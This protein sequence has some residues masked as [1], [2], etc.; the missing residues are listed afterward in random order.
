MLVVAP[1][2][3]AA[4]IWALT[5][6]GAAGL[7]AVPA[8]ASAANLRPATRTAAVSAV[9]QAPAVPATARFVTRPQAA[10]LPP[11]YRRACPPPARPGQMACMA[12]VPAGRAA[13]SPDAV[14]AGYDPATLQNAY[15]LTAAAAKPA[16]GETVAIVDAYDDPTAAHDVAQ[17]RLNYG[18]PPCPACLKVVN[19]YGGSSP[20]GV[21][22]AGGWELEESVD[23]EM[24]SAI[25]PNC[26]ILLVEAN[27][28]SISDLSAAER[29]ATLRAN[30]VSNSWGSGAEF[31]GENAF[32][33]DFYR[34]GVAIT[35]AAGDNGYGTQFPAVSPYVTAVGGTTLTGASPTSAGSQAAW[36]GTGSGCAS[37]EPQPSWQAGAVPSG[38]Q[39]RTDADLSADADPATG[40]AVYDTTLPFKGW[41]GSPI[42]GTSVSTPIV[43]ASYAL[44]D[45]SAGGPGDGLIPG[46]FPAAYPYQAPGDFTDVTAGSNGSCEAGRAYLCHGKAGYDGPTGLGTPDGTGGL[47]GPSGNTVSVIS[48]GTQV[49]LPGAPVSLA[50]QALLTDPAGQPDYSVT[51]P[52][53]L[54]ANSGGISGTAPG[55]PG[56]YHVTVTVTDSGD[57]SAQQS[58]TFAVVVVARLAAAHPGYGPIRLDLAGKCLSDAGNSSAAGTRAEI[59]TCSG[60]A[61]QNWAFIPGGAP[62]GPGLVKIHGKCLTI[63]PGIRATLQSCT[64]AGSQRWQYQA[65]DQ[66]YNPGTGKCLAD[67]GGSRVNGRQVQVSPCN[68]APD[69]SWTLPAGPVLAGIAGRCL[70]DPG[71]SGQAGTRVEIAA[72]RA[73]SSQKWTMT[74]SGALGI[75]GRCLQVAGRSKNDG[76]GA[77]LA[78]CGSSAAQ[79]WLAGPNGQL[80]NGNS[81]RCLADPANSAAAG[82]KLAQEDCYSQPGEIWAI[83]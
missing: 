39:N 28:D 12:L 33:E 10:A 9:R 64:G 62:A 83:S 3:R 21:D 26:N 18:L 43:A 47:T 74:R 15:G 66:L 76:A 52:A 58:V 72:C 34:P 46:T 19:Q 57:A 11:G 45:V 2:R 44:A 75:R 6:L 29:Y 71:D 16:D 24:V 4:L 40:V 36:S 27:S 50:I 38:C 79:Q 17:Y 32:D 48:P 65:G 30:V 54:L 25:C 51:G 55:R 42:G 59:G 68:G 82:P 37:L 70:T 53:T 20:P 61:A 80:L 8:A 63:R 56:V 31:I 22:S 7:A 1:A 73:S 13:I 67:P 78:R 77:V 69:Q 23:L 60:H 49:Y 81:G 14:P 35:A 41:V 5:G